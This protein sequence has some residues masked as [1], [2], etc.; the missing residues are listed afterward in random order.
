[1]C[2]RTSYVALTGML[3]AGAAYSTTAGPVHA[4]VKLLA[5]VL[6]EAPGF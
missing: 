3:E 1:M 4:N 2:A 5:V 6:S